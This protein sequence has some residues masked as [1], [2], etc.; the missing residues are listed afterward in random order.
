MQLKLDN[1]ANMAVG[2]QVSIV[3]NQAHSLFKQI[4]VR[5][6]A[7][8][9]SPQTDTYHHKVSIKTVLNNDRDDEHTILKPEGWFNG[10]NVCDVHEN[11]FT[12]NE[13]NPDHA[14]F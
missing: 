14:D 11:A 6:N 5:L 2:T 7:T 1:N 9:I 8:L 3:N 12:A 10:L 4:N 13:L